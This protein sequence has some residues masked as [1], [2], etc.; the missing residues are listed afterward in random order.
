MTATS[1]PNLRDD[2]LVYRFVKFLARIVTAPLPED[3][4]LLLL[5]DTIFFRLRTAPSRFFALPV[6]FMK[7]NLLNVSLQ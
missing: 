2:D 3:G 5:F 1:L 4:G 6:V 7:V